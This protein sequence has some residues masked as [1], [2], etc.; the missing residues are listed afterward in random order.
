MISSEILQRQPWCAA[1]LVTTMQS[2]VCE[3]QCL[4][5]PLDDRV[6]LL[7]LETC[8]LGI[9]KQHS[10]FLVSMLRAMQQAGNTLKHDSAK[11]I[12]YTCVRQV[13]DDPWL[14]EA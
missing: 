14:S 13:A 11:C 1:Y 7:Q 8:L 5:L 2:Q 9:L 4:L 12:V 10:R 6:L 3:G